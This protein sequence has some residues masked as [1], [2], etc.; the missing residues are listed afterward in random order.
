MMKRRAR[1]PGPAPLERTER[2]GPAPPR[3]VPAG[4]AADVL[5]LQRLAG[6]RAVAALVARTPRAEAPPQPKDTHVIVPKLGT[7]PLLS[8]QWGVGGQDREGRSALKELSL[9]SE[10]GSH[11]SALW[12]AATDGTPLGTVEVVL[13]KDGKPYG[14]IKLHNAMVSSYSTGGRSG[15]H[16]KPTETWSLNVESIEWVSADGGARGGGDSGAG[17]G[18]VWDYDAPG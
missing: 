13:M 12:R 18:S 17:V 5:A 16:H 2:G 8:F 11:S 10:V 3:A 9:S 14:R 1:H 6:N 4:P 7:I 15:G